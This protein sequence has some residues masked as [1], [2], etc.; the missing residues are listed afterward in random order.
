L[1]EFLRR[2]GGLEENKKAVDAGQRVDG[3][4]SESGK[5]KD[6]EVLMIAR[7]AK[8]GKKFIDLFDG[9]DMSN[10]DNDP[11]RADLS[12]CAMLAFYCQGNFEQIDRLFRESRLYREKWERLDYRTNTINR[13]I[14]FCSGKYYQSPGRPKKEG[15]YSLVKGF[16]SINGL[17]AHL[18]EQMI[19]VKYNLITNRLDVDGLEESI[20]KEHTQNALP[21]V[22]Y[23]QLKY[24]YEKVSKGDVRD[25]LGIIGLR[26]KYNPVLELIKGVKWDGKDRLPEVYKIL[27]IAENDHL[28]RTLVY[29]WLWQCLS[30]AKNTSTKWEEPYGAD[31]ALVLVGKQRIGK[32]RF[33]RTIAM[34]SEYYLEGAKLNPDNTDNVIS[35]T[36]KWIVELGEIG[37]T[38]RYNLDS[39]KAFITRQEDTYRK[40]YGY[41]E[42]IL[43]R[44][45]SYCGTCND[46][47][48]LIDKTGN[49]RF[50]TVLTNGIE[51]E[52]L[53]QLNVLQ[54]WA[55]VEAKT[56]NDRQGYRLNDKEHEELEKRNKGH[57][58][59]VK[60]LEEILD[61]IAKV[62]NHVLS[63]KEVTIS[64]FKSAHEVL[65][66]YSVRQIYE[67]LDKAGIPASEQR[68]RINGK[69]GRYRMLPMHGQSKILSGNFTNTKKEEDLPEL[70]LEWQ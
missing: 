62:D 34:S 45:T 12:L 48:Y 49:R 67:A 25:Y 53:K 44:K 14:E 68:T 28:S 29:K 61:L 35:V 52:R 15:Q 32:T 50:W 36:N 59:P 18:K 11:N 66:N 64:D 16:L 54:V 63:Y 30:M 4:G 58:K 40:P 21:T 41:S 2:Y 46:T 56:K 55:Q 1:L 70:P 31:G 42:L 26:K 47:E 13:A 27:R 20:T 6:Q 57:E 33:F 60:G 8:N 37:S 22:V 19:S 9:G 39:L 43:A 51:L 69:L 38:F 7:K 23:D 65:K 5:D 3:K 17:E 24:V 10:Q